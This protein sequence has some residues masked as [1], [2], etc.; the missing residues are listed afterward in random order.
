MK[1]DDSHKIINIPKDLSNGNDSLLKKRKPV[2]DGEA[3]PE[4]LNTLIEDKH[5]YY[6]DILT[7]I[8]E[9]NKNANEQPFTEILGFMPLRGDFDVEFD[10]DAE[11]F[12]AEMEFN[13]DDEPDEIE[14]KK[15]IL[16][17][18][19]KRL[20]ERIKRK[21]FVVERG[22]LDL[23]KQNILDR[24]KTKE[25]KEIYN[26]LK[27]FARFQ[28]PE[29]HDKLVQNIVKERELRRRIEELLAYKRL[30]LKTFDDVEVNIF[31]R[32]KRNSCWTKDSKM[33]NITGGRR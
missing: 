6:E 20:D 28:T 22:L 21:K 27:V 30:G 2:K 13:E 29:E 4:K 24:T 5:K 7:V 9:K 31:L 8:R 11:L 14:M 15:K 33:S 25:E 10:N 12:L 17:I 23:K 3:W 1:K 26:V 18:Y 19:N 32:K 16:E